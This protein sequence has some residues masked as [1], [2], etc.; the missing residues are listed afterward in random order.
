MI[1]ST[2]MNYAWAVKIIFITRKR[3]SDKHNFNMWVIKILNG[4]RYPIR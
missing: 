2:L 1:K 4:L 3:L